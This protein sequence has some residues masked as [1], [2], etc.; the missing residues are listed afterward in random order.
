MCTRRK[1]IIS[2]RIFK[3]SFFSKL[4][5]TFLLRS[6]I[7]LV[8][9]HLSIPA[10]N[11]HIFIAS[12]HICL[13]PIWLIRMLENLRTR[14]LRNSI[15]SRIH[16]FNPRM[17]FTRIERVVISLI[18]SDTLTRDMLKLKM[19]RNSCVERTSVTLFFFFTIAFNRVKEYINGVI[20]EAIDSFFLISTT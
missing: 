9:L 15:R 3:N 2:D 1:Y 4:S 10:S 8:T 20:N 11:L 5:Y 19:K 12:W 13:M 18:F 17:T 7:S 6:K 14:Y 16:L